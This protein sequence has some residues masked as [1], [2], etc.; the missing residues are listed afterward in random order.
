[1]RVKTVFFDLDGTLTDP[2]LGIT[3]SIQFALQSL[4]LEVPPAQ[5]LTWCIGPPLL[6]S[7][8]KLSSEQLAPQ[9]LALYRERFSE[10]GLFENSLYEGIPELLAQL[11]A[12]GYQLHVA[13]S[14]PR[15]FVAR[16]IEH[17]QLD[18]Y[19]DEIFGAELDGTRGDKTELLSYALSSTGANART[20]AMV[21]DRRFDIEGANRNGLRSVGVTWGYGSQAELQQAGAN[22]LAHSPIEVLACVSLAA[23]QNHVL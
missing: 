10:E 21:G 4:E 14:K 19:F 5:E 15:I 11:V 20:A 12:D 6:D 8:R 22:R 13:S 23:S 17:F 7:L 16:I 1:M 3:R 18:T 9:A 2:M